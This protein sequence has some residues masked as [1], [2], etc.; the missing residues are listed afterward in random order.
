M[1]NLSDSS[2]SKRQKKDLNVKIPK[3][4]RDF[5]IEMQIKASNDIKSRAESEGYTKFSKQNLT[6]C[7]L[8]EECEVM[9]KLNRKYE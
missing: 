9:R 2:Q 5:D 3:Q 1:V 8:T 7:A 6:E 4:A